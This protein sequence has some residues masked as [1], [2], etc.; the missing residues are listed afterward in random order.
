MEEGHGR[1]SRIREVQQTVAVLL[2]NDDLTFQGPQTFPTGVF[3]LLS[4]SVTLTGGNL[5]VCNECR[6]CSP[7][8]GSIIM[9]RSCSARRP[10]HARPPD[11]LQRWAAAARYGGERS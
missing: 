7:L 2:G 6:Q 8:R 1:P 3:S 4:R 11:D 5:D 10:R 9:S